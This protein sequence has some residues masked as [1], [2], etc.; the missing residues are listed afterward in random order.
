MK[1]RK[2][3]TKQQK[4]SGSGSYRVFRRV[5]VVCLFLAILGASLYAWRFQGQSI[6]E[7]VPITAFLI[8]MLEFMLTHI[9]HK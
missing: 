4:K 9:L 3:P 7:I 6:S 8:V 1:K 2:K 5:I